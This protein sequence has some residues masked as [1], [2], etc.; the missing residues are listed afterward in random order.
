MYFAKFLYRMKDIRG[1]SLVNLAQSAGDDS[2]SVLLTSTS[3]QH[4]WQEQGSDM[5]MQTWW[6]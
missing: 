3:V 6:H 5:G 1:Q 4:T 2:T